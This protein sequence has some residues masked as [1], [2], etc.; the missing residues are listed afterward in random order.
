MKLFGHYLHIHNWIYFKCGSDILLSY[1]CSKCGKIKYVNPYNS[2]SKPYVIS[3]EEAIKE[4]MECKNRL[5]WLLNPIERYRSY[6]LD[7]PKDSEHYK[8]V[9]LQFKTDELKIFDYETLERYDEILN[10]LNSICV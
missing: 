3:R 9:R 8:E 6:G 5:S 10:Q 1:Y 7:I 2:H 4:I